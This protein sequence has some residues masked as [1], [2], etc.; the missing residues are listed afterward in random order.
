ML[1][2]LLGNADLLIGVFAFW[3]TLFGLSLL[4]ATVMKQQAFWP[5]RVRASTL[6]SILTSHFVSVDSKRVMQLLNLLESTRMKN[7]GRG[8]GYR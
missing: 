1:W 4:F 3:I 6:E 7:R 8:V 2:L 5:L